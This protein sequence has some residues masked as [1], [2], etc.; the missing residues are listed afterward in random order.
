MAYRSGRLDTRLDPPPIS[1][2]HHPLSRTARGHAVDKCLCRSI[3]FVPF[4]NAGPSEDAVAPSLCHRAAKKVRAVSEQHS[5]AMLELT[6]GALNERSPPRE[7]LFDPL[8]RYR[9]ELEQKCS[10]INLG[11]LKDGSGD[12]EPA[13]VRPAITGGWL[14]IIAS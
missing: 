6:R 3:A 4:R 13:K 12:E 10:P 2:R 8:L 1:F 9:F 14:D 5:A 7:G 11:L